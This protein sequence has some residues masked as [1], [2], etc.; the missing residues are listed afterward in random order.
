[1]VYVDQKIAHIKKLFLYAHILYYQ[2]YTLS[3][4][5][6]HFCRSIKARNILSTNVIVVI[7]ITA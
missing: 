2:K 6:T 3:G 1:M 7:C 4:K 5:A